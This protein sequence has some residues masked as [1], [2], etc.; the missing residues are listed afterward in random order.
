MLDE[1]IPDEGRIGV[2]T[3]SMRNHP[4]VI[5]GNI[6]S[7]AIAV[8]IILLLN[9]S[10]Y[11]D[12]PQAL[13]DPRFEIMCALLFAGLVFVFW[14]R[15]A[16]TVYTFDENELTVKRSTVFK[17]DVHIQ[18]SRLASVNVRRGIVNHI[19]GTTELLFNVN[20]SVNTSNA[21]ARLTLKSD[22]ADRLR[23]TISSRILN[24]DMAMETEKE[25]ESL[26][27]ISNADVILHGLFGQPTSR[28]L[29][30]LA[31]LIYSIASVFYGN[32]S[33]SLFAILLFALSTALPWVRTILRYYN[34]RIYRVG[35]TITV[36]SGLIS[37][38]RSSFNIKKVNMV[39]IRQPLLARLMGKALLEAEVVGLADSDGLPLLCPLKSRKL[40]MDMGGKL[41]PEF[42]VDFERR[43]QP[44]NA[45]LPTMANRLVLALIFIA[46]G[47]MLFWAV[48]NATDESDIVVKVFYA[49]AFCVTVICPILVMIHGMLAH[50]NREFFMD[51][52]VFVLVIG[53][54]DRE[55]DYIKYDKVQIA[56]VS[57]GPVQRRFGVGR[58]TVSIMSSTGAKNVTSGVFARDDLDRIPEEVMDRILDGR[59][60]YRDYQ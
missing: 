49:I 23:E 46:V 21:E 58:C 20:S 14:R 19:F 50:G 60:D 35:D 41:I 44:K 40:V 7:A 22:E 30:G 45:F 38:Y 2:Q 6:I 28:A 31:M 8:G 1:Q 3:V 36:Q 47:L 34:Y 52:D 57:V 37:N 18:Y 43:G 26:I 33:G 9:V 48:R 12:D 42:L 54:Y 16:L 29:F 24:R 11:V 32:G 56:S 5:V 13:L 17:S 4:S 15:W 59:Y 53:A 55:T 39:R 10:R 51:S 27:R 25:I